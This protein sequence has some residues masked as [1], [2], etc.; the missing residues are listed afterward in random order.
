MGDPYQLPPVCQPALFDMVT[1]AYARL[2][3]DG[4]LWTDEF[5]MLEL[6][7]I[8]RQRSDRTFAELLCRVRMSQCNE[9]DIAIL[10]SRVITKEKPYPH[11]ALHVYKKNV[12]VNEHNMK[13]LNKLS[14]TEQHITIEAEDDTR[15][16]T[17]QTQISKMPK[18]VTATGGLP[19]TLVVAEGAKVMLT[20]N[21][22][23]SDGLVNG[24]RGVIASVVKCGERVSRVLVQFNNTSIGAS[25]IQRSQFRTQYP[26][27]VPISRHTVKFT[28]QG[29]RGAEVTRNQFPLVLAWATTI[30]K[31][32]GL[33][34]DELVVDMKGGRFSPGQAY[35]AFSRVKSLDKLHLINFKPCCITKSQKVEEEMI[36]L[37]AKST[38]PALKNC[39]N[40]LPNQAQLKI[41]LLNIRSY[42]AKLA[43][44][45]QDSFILTADIICLTETWLTPQQETVGFFKQIS[46]YLVA[47]ERMKTI[48][49]VL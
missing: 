37:R 33:T 45:K 8:M 10:K 19:T 4:S 39:I 23:V 27:A 48:E 25:A 18:N 41:A 40:E 34:L 43:D 21:V 1:D 12:D 47:T 42:R 13:M 17:T 26:T 35:V 14:P 28:V 11:D 3:K 20:V 6:D 38:L 5:V 31:V 15:G 49:V 36:R 22:D 16:Q 32:Q 9:S 44:L 7:E 30:H 46:M 24:A 29:I 2:H